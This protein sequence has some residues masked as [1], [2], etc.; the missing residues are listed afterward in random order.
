MT[1]FNIPVAA[2]QVTVAGKKWTLEDESDEEEGGNANDNSETTED[3][4][5]LD[6]YMQVC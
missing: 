1:K 4:D 3:V 6:A 2:I 5:P